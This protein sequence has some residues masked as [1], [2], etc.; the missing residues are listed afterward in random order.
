MQDKRG[1]IVSKKDFIK[2]GLYA[3][4]EYE[5]L[6]VSSDMQQGCYNLGV[7]LAE[8]QVLFVDQATESNIN[9]KLQT[10]VPQIQTLQRQHNVK[11]NSGNYAR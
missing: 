5:G 10:W 8:D 2:D 4:E 6:L 1:S 9:E 3:K 7:Q 11:N